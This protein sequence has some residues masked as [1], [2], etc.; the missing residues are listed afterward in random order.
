VGGDAG[1]LARITVN[2]VA[3]LGSIGKFVVIEFSGE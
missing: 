3:N 2:K 1:A